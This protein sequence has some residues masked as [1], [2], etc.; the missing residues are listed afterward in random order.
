VGEASKVDIDT[1]GAELTDWVD[2]FQINQ[3]MPVRSTP[4][5]PHFKVPLG[6]YLK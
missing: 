6:K 4:Y 3:G 1:Q 2:I 5:L